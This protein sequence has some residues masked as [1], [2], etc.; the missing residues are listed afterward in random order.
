MGEVKNLVGA[1]KER[2]KSVVT[3]CTLLEKIDEIIDDVDH[4][5]TVKQSDLEGE[6]KDKQ[7]ENHFKLGMLRAVDSLFR[8]GRAMLEDYGSDLDLDV[9]ITVDEKAAG[10]EDLENAPT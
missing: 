1:D 9:S 3:D 4:A 7:P 10:G 6:G 8:R 5:L 2:R